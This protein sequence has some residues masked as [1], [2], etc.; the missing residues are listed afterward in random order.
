MTIRITDGH[1]DAD[2]YSAEARPIRITVWTNGNSDTI[3]IDNLLDQ[4]PLKPDE[5]TV[6]GLTLPNPGRYTIR[7]GGAST[8]TAALDVRAPGSR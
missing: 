5:P 3:A 7:L 2:V 6:I 4:Q 8:A 1:F